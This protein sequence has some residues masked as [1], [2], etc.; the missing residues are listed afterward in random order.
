RQ[1]PP[2]LAPTSLAV[3]SAG[4]PGES[5]NLT[6]VIQA[7]PRTA[8]SYLPPFVGLER[9]VYRDQGIDLELPLMAANMQV[10]GLLTGSVGISTGGSALRAAMQGA[11][12]KVVFYYYQAPMWELVAARDIHTVTDLKGKA[13]GLSARGSSDEKSASI[14]FEQAGLDPDRDVTFA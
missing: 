7:V 4:S 9:Q 5:R 1:A 3:P 8:F 2:P 11:P 14:L 10:A 12:L 6:R 13:M